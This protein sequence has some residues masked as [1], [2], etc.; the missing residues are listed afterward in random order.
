MTLAAF[1]SFAMLIALSIFACLSALRYGL[2][3]FISAEASL[4]AEYSLITD[5]KTCISLG[6]KAGRDF[7]SELTLLLP[8]PGAF[9]IPGACVAALAEAPKPLPER[10]SASF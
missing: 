6:S 1:A 9:P 3:A 4:G 7:N 2:I 10:L 5:A 8:E